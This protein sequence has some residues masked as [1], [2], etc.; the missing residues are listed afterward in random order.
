MYLY[1]RVPV[2]DPEVGQTSRSAEGEAF[3]LV[4][5]L[6]VQC[7]EEYRPSGLKARSEPAAPVDGLDGFHEVAEVTMSDGDYV[8]ASPCGPFVSRPW[9]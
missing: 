6:R 1:P 2:F 5:P 7:V 3:F 8:A 4:G 9:G